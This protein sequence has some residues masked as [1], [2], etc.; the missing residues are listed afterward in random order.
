MTDARGHNLRKDALC[1][2]AGVVSAP[3]DIEPEGWE[4]FRSDSIDWLKKKYGDALESVIEHTD[5]SHPHLHFYVV[6]KPGQRFESIH[7]GRAAA[8]AKKGQGGKKG[9]QNQA[10]KASMREFQDEFFEKVGI[11]HGFTR[12]GPGKR[13]LTREEW[14]L[15]QIQAAAAAKAITVA[16]D[17]VT[18]SKVEA[19]QIKDKAVQDGK[20][21]AART[22]KKADQIEKAAEKRGFETGVKTLETL[23]WWRKVGA[24]LSSAVRERDQLR[25]KVQVIEKDLETW[26]NKARKYFGMGKK[27]DIELKEVKPKLEA[28]EDE[29]SVT[30]YK[31]KQAA[32]LR[33]ENDRLSRS[34]GDAEHRID[35]LKHTVKDLKDQLYP[36]P[37]AKPGQARKAIKREHESSFER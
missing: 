27:L 35:S 33:E 21:F 25:E 30:R 13:R 7:Q 8:N 23:P 37:E 15:E 19:Q 11:E 16:H 3:H 31:A 20:E 12:I 17:T 18:L 29:L 2:V 36:E 5:E 1:L 32:L 24:F 14:K 34:L 26:T 22:L 28:A 4:K 10:Y 6:P 9:E